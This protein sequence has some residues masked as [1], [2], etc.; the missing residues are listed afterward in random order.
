MSGVKP[1][2]SLYAFMTFLWN[3]TVQYGE[4][5]LYLGD[6]KSSYRNGSLLSVVPGSGTF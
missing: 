5:Q 1:L 3:I 2:L 4:Q 6:L